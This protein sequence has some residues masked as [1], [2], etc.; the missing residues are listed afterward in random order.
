[1]EVSMSLPNKDPMPTRDTIETINFNPPEDFLASAQR[2]LE[3]MFALA[4]SDS[5]VKVRFW[6]NAKGFAGLLQIRD[7]QHNFFAKVDSSNLLKLPEILSQK[8]GA[9]LK[10]WKK[11]RVFT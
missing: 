1:M 7:M 9:Q 10:E 6:K 4:P 11:T 8:M 3:K 5:N 2:M